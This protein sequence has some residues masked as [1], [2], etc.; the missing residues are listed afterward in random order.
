[1]AADDNIPQ[2]EKKVLKEMEGKY[3]QA[4]QALTPRFSKFN[5]Y[6]DLYLGYISNK[7]N[8]WKSAVFDPESFEKVERMVSHLFAT[9]PR[10]RYMPREGADTAGVRIADELFKYQWDKDGQQMQRKLMRIGRNAGIFGT[11]FGI[12]TWRFERRKRKFVMKDGSV[13]TKWVTSWDDPYFQD[14]YIYD[15]FPDPTATYVE[16][17][18][19]FIHNEY[20]TIEELENTNHKV[21]GVKRYKNLSILKEKA[22]KK[23]SGAS[24]DSFRDRFSQTKNIDT[25]EQ[26]GRILVRRYYDRDRWVSWC[27][28]YNLIIEDRENPY[29]HGDLPIHLLTDHD[30]S[31]QLFGIGELEPIE[32]LQR[33]L[34]SVLNQ[35]LDNVRMIMNPAVKTLAR[36]KYSKEWKMA[37]GWKWRMDRMDE[38]DLFQIPDATGNTF[39]Q[40]ANYFKDAMSRAL[41]Y[42][43][44]ISRNESGADKTAA[45][46]RAASGEQ[47]ARLKSKEYNVDAF[48]QRLATQWMQLNQQFITKERVIRIVGKDAIS[49]FS[50]MDAFNND[51]EAYDEETGAPKLDEL[52]KPIMEPQMKQ[53][54]MKGEEVDKWRIGDDG[55]FGL[56]VIEPDDLMG[57]FDYIVETGSTTQVDTAAQQ[58]NTESALK[59]LIE[60]EEKLMNEGKTIHY[61]PVVEKDLSELG[62]KNTDE[63]I[64]SVDPATMGDAT[65][66]ELNNMTGGNAGGLP[67]AG[68]ALPPM[69]G[70]MPPQGGAPMTP[71]IPAGPAPTGMPMPG[72]APMQPGQLPVRSRRINIPMPAP[73]RRPGIPARPAQISYVPR[74]R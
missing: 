66:N 36:S 44:F 41:G 67:L 56:L 74:P 73:S 35:R 47:N 39:M 49:L 70:G 43:D 6:E 57:D 16:D 28:D 58:A 20:V 60:V 72:G 69:P 14:L 17:L 34:N 5:D 33:G 42:Q 55:A 40:T 29:W 53:I 7:D 32:R 38:V 13:Q 30:Y 64:V 11:G 54:M 15:C 2:T 4:Y 12:L 21:N 68:G 1:M 22:G 8:P 52:G 71:Q 23:K 45:E 3:D 19:W 37:P 46:I 9:K 51:A 48:I 61:S 31:N 27:P 24:T 50:K 25:T 62:F 26:E 18:A 65:S 63:I 10:G 59:M